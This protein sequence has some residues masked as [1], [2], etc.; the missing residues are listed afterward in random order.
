[1]TPS[2][3]KQLIKS[4]ACL[5]KVD[6]LQKNKLILA[7]ATGLIAGHPC[8]EIDDCKEGDDFSQFLFNILA[9]Q[10]E[11]YCKHFGVE[12][13]LAA[14]DGYLILTDVTIQRE[15]GVVNMSNLIVFY[16]QIVGMSIGDLN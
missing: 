13:P 1:M 14:D 8:L 5:P 11:E 15:N 2:L 4:A 6:G 16:D 9:Q 3:K 10:T 7:T 12:K